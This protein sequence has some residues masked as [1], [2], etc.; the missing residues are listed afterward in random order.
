MTHPREGDHWN[1]ERYL[2]SD[3]R[4]TPHPPIRPGATPLYDFRDQATGEERLRLAQWE[5]VRLKGERDVPL[6]A[7]SV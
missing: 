1:L 2:A 4:F 3:R 7:E 6:S 5:A